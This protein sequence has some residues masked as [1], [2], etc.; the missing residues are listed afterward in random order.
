MGVGVGAKAKAL[1]IGLGG[2]I[3]GPGFTGS[4]KAFIENDCGTWKFVPFE[5]EIGVF[6]G[7]GA[8]GELGIFGGDASPASTSRAPGVSS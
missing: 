4:G 8:S 2:I 3:K 1:G 7:L 6:V 5:Q